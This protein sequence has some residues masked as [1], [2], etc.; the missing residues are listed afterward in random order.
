MHA[1][2]RNGGR[3][4][5]TM[6]ARVG[7][8]AKVTVSVRSRARVQRGKRDRPGALNGNNTRTLS[9][10]PA[11]SSQAAR[12]VHALMSLFR[13]WPSPALAAAAFA[14]VASAVHDGQDR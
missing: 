3:F 8:G 7:R 13:S 10:D 9:A 1:R 5:V 11:P 6:R 14:R 4:R 12:F 2:T